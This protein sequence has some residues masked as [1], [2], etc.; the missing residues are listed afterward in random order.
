[1]EVQV[2]IC[3]SHHDDRYLEDDSLL[4]HLKGLERD[5][6]VTFWH[7]GNI[8]TGKPW[9]KEIQTKIINSGVALVLVS[10]ALLNSEYVMNQ[11]IPKFLE[12]RRREG[13]VIFPII[14]S[15]C[16]WDLYEWLKNTEC[17]PKNGKNIEAHYC[18]LGTRK[19]LFH[20]IMTDLR[21]QINQISGGARSTS[22][23]RTKPSRIPAEVN[24]AL[25]KDR[26]AKGKPLYGESREIWTNPFSMVTANDMKPEE[27]LSLFVGD[28]TDIQ[29]IE[30]H[31]DTM[32]EGQRGTGKTMVLR[33]LSL[34]THLKEWVEKKKRPEE[35]FLQ[36]PDNYVGIF[37][38]L[39][40][41]VFDKSDLSGIKSGDRKERLFEHRLCLHCLACEDGILD[42]VGTIISIK[43]IQSKALK[44]ISSYLAD[45]LKDQRLKDCVDWQDT[46]DLSKD[47]INSQVL[48]E[49][50]HLGSLSPGGT[51]TAFNPYLTMSGQIVPFLELVK[52]VLG[53]SCPFFL[54]LDDFDVLSASQQTCVFRTASARRLSTVCFKYGIMSLGKKTVLAGPARTYRPG[55]DYDPVCLD[56]TDEGLQGDFKMASETVIIK[57][58][59]SKDWPTGDP[60]QLFEIWGR[61]RQIRDALKLEMSDEWEHLPARVKPKKFDNYWTKYGNARY[62]QKLS[63]AKTNHRYSGF[64]EIVD[65]SSGIYRQLLE[66]C[67]NIVDKALASGWT[68]VSSSAISAKIQNEAIREY[69]DAM[70]NT[71]SQTAGDT[72]DILAGDAS[73]TSKHMVTLIESLSDLFYFRL[74][75]PSREPEIFCIAIKDDLKNNRFAKSLLDVAVRESILQRRGSD[76]T[77]KTPGGPPLPTYMLNRRLAPRRSLGIRMQ[78]RIEVTSSSVALAATDRR[79][80]MNLFK[81]LR[82]RGK[83]YEG[84]QLFPSDQ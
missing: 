27:I 39:E 70:L 81:R 37:C 7:D 20:E 2:F 52:T 61:G 50:I 47:T 8:V 5:G 82:V 60:K 72:T 84:P 80:F 63:L 42:T 73:I 24:T 21:L 9:N 45:M 66:I 28:Y 65:I 3:H 33:Y 69:S 55:D 43:P 53:L 48:E 10:Q 71:L 29:K 32:V 46:F 14:L 35:Q 44:R 58:I 17:L 51:P 12:K 57:R 77:P 74:H 25:Q 49:D 11:E 26:K 59:E 83:L 23:V 31:F 34:E 22:R 38:R 40:Q 67:K 19:Q 16:E 68:P 64:S 13:L 79:A 62:F 15:A 76:Y 4:G 30:K 54:M 1:M 18:Q 6:T 75:S 36:D 41:G 78:G 56:W